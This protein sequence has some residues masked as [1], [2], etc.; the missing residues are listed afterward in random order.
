MVES[1]KEAKKAQSDITLKTDN[2]SSHL[3]KAT[4]HITSNLVETIYTQTVELFKKQIQ[5]LGFKKEE[6]PGEYLKENYK[7]EINNHLRNFLFKHLVLD[8]LMQQIRN[9]KIILTNYP[10][11][12]D[13]QIHPNKEADFIFN[14]SVADPIELKEWKHFVFRPPKR[15]LYKDLD[16]QVSLF[17]KKETTC[18]KKL[19]PEEIQ[20][21]DWVCFDANL[22]NKKQDRLLDQYKSNFW[23]KINNIEIKKPFQFSLLGK[24]VGDSFVTSVLPLKN[25]FSED[26]ETNQYPFLITIKAITK[27]NHL[28]LESFKT[29]FKLKSKLDAHKKLIEVF[30]Y[31]NDISQRKAII[32]ELFHLLLSKHRFEVPKHFIIRRQEDILLSLRSLPDYQVYKMQKDFNEQVAML[33]EKELKEEILIDQITYR[34]NL[35]ID[36]KDIQ[37]YLYLFNNN[38]LKEFVYFKPVL[39][40]LEN[41]DSPLQTSLLTQAALREKTLNH[42]I[43]VLTK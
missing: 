11:L 14:V 4:V 35:K 3:L 33:A 21:Y 17:L 32:E 39:E 24:K 26:I 12:T 30:S 2:I 15:K 18:F 27:G 40:K 36:D 28:S 7:E 19:R 34:E 31:R 20:E 22:L 6:A 25:N 5:L 1:I 16:K 43:H 29:N 42:V 23:I 13:I 8:F 41:T 37:H 9:Q 38:R 10:R